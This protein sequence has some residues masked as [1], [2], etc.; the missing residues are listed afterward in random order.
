VGVLDGVRVWVDVAVFVPVHVA[1]GVDV[2]VGVAEGEA[3]NDAV[4]LAVGDEL[5][6]AVGVG[7]LLGVTVGNTGAKSQPPAHVSVMWKS[8]PPQPVHRVLQVSELTPS[9]QK[10]Q[11][12]KHAQHE[13]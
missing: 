10:P 7:L 5:G 13:A 4:G 1:V 3:V 8:S 12:P 6:V 2:L 9:S 11:L